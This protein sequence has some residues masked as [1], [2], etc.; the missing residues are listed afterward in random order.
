[1]CP[2]ELRSGLDEGVVLAQAVCGLC[3]YTQREADGLFS[4]L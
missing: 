2:R 3:V 4:V 1:M